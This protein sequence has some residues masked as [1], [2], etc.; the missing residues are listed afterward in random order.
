MAP[1]CVCCRHSLQ[2]CL[3]PCRNKRMLQAFIA[4]LPEAMQRQMYDACR[5]LVQ[6]AETINTCAASEDGAVVA[7]ACPAPAGALGSALGAQICLW[8]VATATC[9]HVIHHHKH[10]VQ[11]SCTC[12]CAVFH[13]SLLRKLIVILSFHFQYPFPYPVPMPLVTLKM[14]FFVL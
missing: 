13:Y 6:H 5:R 9:L 14:L 12:I 2:C 4:V 11:V 10:A 1:A 7:S 8:D 3:K